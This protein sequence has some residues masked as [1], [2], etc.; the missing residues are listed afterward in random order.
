MDDWAGSLRFCWNPFIQVKMFYGIFRL[1]ERGL[2]YAW[3]SH[4]RL[5]PYGWFTGLTRD[6]K[7]WLDY[8]LAV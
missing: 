6:A 8:V 7:K 3:G 1:L 2:L 5:I 4:R